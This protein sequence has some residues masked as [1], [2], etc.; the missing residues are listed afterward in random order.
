MT[1]R[2]LRAD[3]RAAVMAMLARTGSFTNEE[4]ATAL[5][6][7]DAW[8]VEGDAS[9][10]LTFVA[11]APPADEAILGYVCFGP[12]PLTDGTYDLYWI[13]VDPHTQGRGVGRRLLA[14][15]ESEIAGCGG[16]LVLIE[17]SSQA[18]YQA[19]ARFY[20]RCGYALAARIDNYYRVGDD[21]LIFAKTLT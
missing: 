21:K 2:P 8:V 9:G 15:A 17:T 4:V 16:R 5:E 13:A 20:E 6:L 12:A 19:T 11:T 3:D 10:Y 14:F 1:I 18:S 7:M